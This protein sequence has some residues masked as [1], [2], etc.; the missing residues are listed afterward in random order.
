MILKKKAR[1]GFDV[2]LASGKDQ[3]KDKIVRIAHLG[4]VDTFDLIIAI[5]ALEIA[6]KKIG[7]NVTLGKG[8]SAAQEIL[9][10]GY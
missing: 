2:I 3:W 9:L 6:L 5:S 8:V 1:D 4:Y 10:E 7:H